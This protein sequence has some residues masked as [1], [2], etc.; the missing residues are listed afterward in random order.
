MSKD[1]RGNKNQK[2]IEISLGDIF[3]NDDVQYEGVGSGSKQ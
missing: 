2:S 1:D 3:F